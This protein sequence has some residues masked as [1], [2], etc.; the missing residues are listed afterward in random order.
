MFPCPFRPETQQLTKTLAG[1]ALLLGLIL[2]IGLWHWAWIVPLGALALD[3]VQRWLEARARPR[4][5]LPDE[6]I[7]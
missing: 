1:L 7:F 3:A 2:W 5:L 4:R 6:V